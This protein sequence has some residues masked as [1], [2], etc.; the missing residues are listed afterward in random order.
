MRYNLNG[1]KFKALSNSENGQVSN[2]TLFHYHQK[3]D[4][5]WTKYQGGEIM[6]G[7]IVGTIKASEL[8]S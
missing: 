1:K 3:G 5:I 8:N 4:I 6:K 2:A 7:S